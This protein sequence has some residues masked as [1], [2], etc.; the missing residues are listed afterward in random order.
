M[1]TMLTGQPEMPEAPNTRAIY[2]LFAIFQQSLLI[3]TVWID[4]EWKESSHLE[5]RFY[6]ES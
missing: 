5:G 4:V 3:D 2:P 6:V 1:A